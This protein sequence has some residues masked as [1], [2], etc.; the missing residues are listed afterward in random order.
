LINSKIS[1]KAQKASAEHEQALI[2]ELKSKVEHSETEA[3]NLKEQVQT[4]KTLE[5]KI[6]EL[7]SQLQSQKKY[8]SFWWIC[9]LNSYNSLQGVRNIGATA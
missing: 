1:L 9:H 5:P 3:R 7:T 2:T 4:A 8:F 6:N